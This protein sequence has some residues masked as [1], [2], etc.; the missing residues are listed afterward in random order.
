MFLCVNMNIVFVR[1]S[2]FCKILI[3]FRAFSSQVASKVPTNG[4]WPE[5][6]PRDN[7]RQP[8]D[9]PNLLR[10]TQCNSP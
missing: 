10:R 1:F 3:N 7:D 6:W 9:P 4:N 8:L 5:H 2:V